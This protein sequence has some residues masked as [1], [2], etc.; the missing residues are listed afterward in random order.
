MEV[1]APVTIRRLGKRKQTYVGELKDLIEKSF[2]RSYTGFIMD[3]LERGFTKEDIRSMEAN[4][5]FYRLPLYWNTL[6]LT[7]KIKLKIFS[8]IIQSIFPSKNFYLGMKQTLRYFSQTKGRNWSSAFLKR[9]IKIKKEDKFQLE[10]HVIPSPYGFKWERPRSFFYSLR[11]YLTPF[12]GHKIGHAFIV[13]KQ[14]NQNIVATGMTGETNYQVLF[15]LFFKKGGFEF[16]FESFR[17]RLESANFVLKDIEKHKQK[18]KIQTL[19][20][21][22]DS[23]EFENCLSLLENWIEGGLYKNYGL[24]FCLTPTRGGSCTSFAVNFLNEIGELNEDHKSQWKRKVHIPEGL[25]KTKQNSV[26]FLKLFLN[27]IVRN[28]WVNKE[29]FNKLLFWDPDLIFHWI[30]NNSQP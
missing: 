6:L 19:T 17:G 25:L 28:R 16:L 13:L 22:L 5:D 11:N 27:L 10:F 3:G 9:E 8:W 21:R 23:H 29:R 4:K 1:L 30:K 2:L 7:H 20:Y 14:N 12:W 15:R 24:P 26:G 18:E